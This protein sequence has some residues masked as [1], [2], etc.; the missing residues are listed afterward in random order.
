MDAFTEGDGFRGSLGFLLRRAQ[1]LMALQA[2]QIFE[3]KGLTL[4]QWLVL[5]LMDEGV[6]TTPGDAAKMLVH[7]TGATTRLIGQLVNLGLV[8][9]T[10]GADDLRVVSL[11]LTDAGRTMARAWAGAMAGFFDELLF[12]FTSAEAATFIG[13]LGRLVD[14]LEARDTS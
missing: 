9:R 7:N 2:E 14:Q 1:K 8:E 4:S 5:K 6:V 12:D 13:L 11:A 10:R 3:G